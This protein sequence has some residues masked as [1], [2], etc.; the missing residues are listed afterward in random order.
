MSTGKLVMLLAALTVAVNLGLAVMFTSPS[1]TEIQMANKVD[2]PQ[3]DVL[4]NEVRRAIDKP[5][6]MTMTK[7][8]KEAI[9]ANKELFDTPENQVALG[10]DKQSYVPG[11]SLEDIEKTMAKVNKDSTVEQEKQNNLE[12]QENLT[13]KTE[14][15]SESEKV[16]LSFKTPMFAKL[17][18]QKESSA[19]QETEQKTTQPTQTTHVEKVEKSEETSAKI[20]SSEEKEEKVEVVQVVAPKET[21]VEKEEKKEEI[22]A[23]E[24]K[25]NEKAKETAKQS[26][27]KESPASGG[28]IETVTTWYDHEVLYVRVKTDKAVKAKTL[29]VGNPERAILDILG[30]WK[31]SFKPDFPE[32]PYSTGM[33][34]GV[35]K[36]KVRFVIDITTKKFTRRLVQIDSNTVELRVNFQ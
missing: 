2:K 24:I 1:R 11:K 19:T 35:Q 36:D 14:R 5:T 4:S 32:N 27:K 6:S 3:S 8:S 20:E 16:D 18:Q 30:S 34:V 31:I 10:D 26:E 29:Y 21:K 28:V 9:E 33:R 22:V 25:A 13:E 7:P 15:G 17:D 23:L 12:K